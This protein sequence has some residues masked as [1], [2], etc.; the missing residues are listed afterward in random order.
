MCEFFRSIALRGQNFEFRVLLLPRSIS[1]L[2]IPTNWSFYP[3]RSQMAE[4]FDDP[5][6][7]SGYSDYAQH[8]PPVSD[9]KKS[10]PHKKTRDASALRKAPQAPKRFKSSYICF[11]MEKQP[12]IKQELGPK[13]TVSASIGETKRVS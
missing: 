6:G 5:A 12:E 11:F 10:P 7:P 1:A 2:F 13:A 3:M 8:Q 4:E 9:K